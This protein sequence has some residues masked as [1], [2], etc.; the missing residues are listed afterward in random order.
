[1]KLSLNR[2]AFAASAIFAILSLR[3][4]AATA[5]PATVLDDFADAS[6]WK[7]VASDGVDLKCSE[8]PGEGDHASSL[9][10]DINFVSGAGFAGIHRDLPLDLP[11]N[12]ELAFSIR[13][14]LP[15]NNL[16][17]KLVDSTGQTVWWVNR[18]VFEFPHD[19]TRLASRRRHFQFAW[20]PSGD[21]LKHAAAI[22]IVISSAQG[23]HGTIYLDDLTFRPLPESKKYSGTPTAS[24]SSTAGPDSAA[25]FAI[26]GDEKT[27]WQSVA[28]DIE[29]KLMVD[30]G[31]S[32][33][34][35]G[36][37]IDWDTTAYP[38]DYEIQF[39][40]DGES[41]ISA[42]AVTACTGRRQYIALPDS[43]ARAVR[44]VASS[45]ATSDHIA[46]RDIQVLPTD[47]SRDP[48]A[49]A[50]EIARRSPRGFYPQPFL[51]EGYFW[52]V[53]GAPSDDH[54]A[55]FSEYGAAEVDDQAWS[56]EPFLSLDGKLH[57]WADAKSAQS[58]ANGYAPVPTAIRDYGDLKL[59]VTAAADG[60]RNSSSL[61]L[62]YRVTNTSPK[63]MS[64]SL[65]LAIRPLQINP[66][67][68]SLKA[69]GGVAR[70]D[71]VS[72]RDT[73]RVVDVD[74][75]EIALGEAPSNFGAAV[76]D[77][78]DVTAFISE[79]KIPPHANVND[80]QRAAT[81]SLEY[82]FDLQPGESRDYV[83]AV[84]FSR[85]TKRKEEIAA[86]LLSAA[87]P[88]KYVLDR[89]QAIID[90]W[91]Q[92]TN[93][94]EL[95]VPPQAADVVNTIRSTLAY[96]LINRDGPSIQPG[97][98][99]Y[100]RSWIRD[101][102]LTATALLR[103]GL[104]QPAREFVDWYAP[105]QF[106]SGKVPCVV[107]RRGPDPVPENDSHGELI[108]AV[109]NVYRFTGDKVFLERNWPHVEKAVAYIETL[110]SQRMTPEYADP[111][112][113]ATHQEPDKP[114]VSLHAFYGLLP[115]SISHEGYCAKPMHSY[116]DDFFTLQGLKDAAEIARVLDKP[117][118]AARYQALADDF[119]TTLY[120]SI[121]QAMTTHGIDYIPGCVELGDFDATSTT[122]ALWPCG[123]LVRLPRQALDRTFDLYWERFLHRRDDPS[124]AWVDYTPYEL[125]CIGSL[126]LL[127]KPDRARQA[128]EF[129]L[130]D[131]R[132]TTWNQWPEVVYREPRTAKFLGDLPHTWCGSDFLNSVRMMFLFERQADDALVLLAGVP[133]SWLS[134]EPVGFRNMPTYGGRISCTVVRTDDSSNY[135]T[136]HIDG[137]CPMPQG[138]IRLTPLLGTPTDATVNDKP[139][140]IDADGRIIIRELPAKI[141][142][143]AADRDLSK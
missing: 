17:F 22:E 118:D 113:T 49:F 134:T 140:E 78:G 137:T 54:E 107:D 67:Y 7:V 58:L 26:D 106:E 61:L 1:M 9:R 48:N 27:L 119:A 133:E 139:A 100:E 53:V 62:H 74:D 14:D 70:I 108:L 103:F 101:G 13:G 80:P 5:E 123:E 98:R 28:T 127:G 110:R 121:D 55:L 99:S 63:P 42:R 4:P 109:M 92:A 75:R 37:A 86:P 79:G 117:A 81:A 35:G 91:A 47:S 112:T 126:L 93:S 143:A 56:I 34:F 50:M 87:D 38:R 60:Q 59:A 95:F 18:R 66:P 43:E 120:A 88:V 142:F 90:Q 20:G 21:A 97:S 40:D 44:F 115:E 72:I 130:H 19:W 12:F 83:L 65:H 136:A 116:W 31:A 128:L 129:F 64:G 105:Y 46:I 73:K 3:I 138:G 94:F 135:L 76:Y 10:L 39:S 102:S 96:I 2:T 85:D 68:Q 82:R 131:R 51:G 32:R 125:R 15:P 8:E 30:F 23:G 71:R 77:E 111:K 104:A 45:P 124:F 69:A 132:P 6:R 57:S 41:W 16:E 11:P 84:P 114:A 36:L 89:Q 33:E 122:I 25:S 29:P 52:T 24:A 141:E